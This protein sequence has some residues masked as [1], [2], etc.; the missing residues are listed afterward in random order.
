MPAHFRQEDR[1][2]AYELIRRVALAE[3]VT[4]DGAA[5]S[6]STIPMLLDERPG[7][8]G[9][10]LGHVARGNP[11]W[12]SFDQR[13]EA[14]AIFRGPQ[15]YVSPSWYPTKAEHGKVVPTWDYA[16]VHL[17]GTLVVHDDDEWKRALV[18]RLTDVHESERAR[19]WSVADAPAEYVAGQLRAIVGIELQIT[20]LEAK[21]KLSQNQP[22]RNRAGVIAGLEQDAGASALEIAAMIRALPEGPAAGER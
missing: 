19:P 13:V 22:A 1:A 7:E 3:L 16:T 11:Q 17:H 21:W 4:W 10:L 15:A 14:L 8:P 5:I 2:A 9:S 18:T 20:R 6:A 12:S